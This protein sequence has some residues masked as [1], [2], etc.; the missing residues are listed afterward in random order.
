MTR[1]DRQAAFSGT[2]LPADALAFDVSRLEAYLAARIARFAGPLDVRQ[3]RGGQSNPTYLLTTPHRRYVL[4]RKPP[5]KLLPSA[6][7]VEREFRVIGALHAQGFPV[8]APVLLCEDA[9]VIGTAFYVMEFVDGRIIWEPHMP[10]SDPSERAAVYRAMNETLARLHTFDPQTIGLGDYGAG[11]DYVARQIARWSKQYRASQ[12]DEI[13]EMERLIAWLPRN[14][15]PAGPVRLVH[16]D[17]RLDNLV[18][19]PHASEVRA[20]L[21]WELSTLGDPLADFTYHLMAWH[22]PRADSGTGTGTLLGH[23][24]A[25]LGI[26]ALSE[27][28]DAYVARTGLDPRPHLPIYLA[29]NFF[30]L[31]AIYQGI[32]GRV[33]DGTASNENAPAMARM[34]RPL[35]R[36]AWAFARDAG[37][38]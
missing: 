38:R 7:A 21:D 18:L 10:G 34:V 20:V 37:A 13:D 26:P 35:A 16:G 27:Y 30:R 22:M 32:I 17:Y 12:T 24:L 14:V 3:F 15:P 11:Q 4:R 28:V 29:Y 25:A 19:A 9:D 8:A 33:R 31:A 23:D 2:K 6:H 36:T 5:G 1:I